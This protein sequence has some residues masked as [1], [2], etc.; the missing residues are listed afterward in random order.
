MI[1]F[2]ENLSNYSGLQVGTLRRQ[3]ERIQINIKFLKKSL[4]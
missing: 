3:Q 4:F 2:L 1:N